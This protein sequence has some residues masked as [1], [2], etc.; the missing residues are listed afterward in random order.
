M[1]N[2]PTVTLLIHTR[3]EERNIADCVRSA[4]GFFDELLVCDMESSDKTKEIAL[5]LGAR[6]I[7]VEQAGSAEPARDYAICQASKDWV[8]VLDAD[9]RATPELI[10]ELQDAIK[11]C[12]GKRVGVIAVSWD[13]LFMGKWLRHGIWGTAYHKRLFRKD[14]YMANRN[15]EMVV[16]VEGGQSAFTNLGSVPFLKVKNKLA[17][18]A[19]P[20]LGTFV[21]R[22]LLR[23]SGLEKDGRSGSG[24]KSSVFKLIYYPIRWFFVSF[25]YYRGYRDGIHGFIAAIGLAMYKFLVYAR[26]YD[27]ELTG[28]QRKVPR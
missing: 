25:L 15:P 16:R 28:P 2:T 4:S 12:E 18:Y 10:K 22:T 11:D 19:Y 20:D 7:V 13:F 6:V 1:S 17:H 8:L 26:F 23:Y 21:E 9:E 5:S 24:E 3:N 27:V 14:V